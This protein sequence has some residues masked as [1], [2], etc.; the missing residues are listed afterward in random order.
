MIG[1]LL[2]AALVVAQAQ[3]T[4]MPT[5]PAMTVPTVQRPAGKSVAPTSGSLPPSAK[6]TYGDATVGNGFTAS[7]PLGPQENI[8]VAIPHY[9][10]YVEAGFIAPPIV[11]NEFSPGSK[12]RSGQSY[13]IRG[14]VEFPVSTLTLM[15]MVDSR[16]YNYNVPLGVVTGP[17]GTGRFVYPASNFIDRDIDVKAG[18]KLIDPRLYA[19]VSYIRVTNNYGFPTRSGLGVGVEKLP[20]LD[21]RTSIHGGVFYYPNVGGLYT[22]AGQPGTYD[23]S[24]K[25]LRYSLAYSINLQKSPLFVDVGYLGDRSK[26]RTNAPIITEH[27]GPYVGLGLHF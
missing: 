20:D 12:G 26:P 19:G 15:A 16:R 9:I 24:Y 13:D 27:H 21:Q 4:A 5:P 10:H 22:L 8:G 7:P 18:V 14:A 1:L 2:G 6:S 11:Y 23:L 25:M 3:P 17:T